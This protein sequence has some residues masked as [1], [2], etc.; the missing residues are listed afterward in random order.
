MNRR[1]FLKTLGA[2]AVALTLSGCSSR[3]TQT[4][5][6]RTKY[7]PRPARNRPN[8]IFIMADDMGYG[9][10][11]VYNTDSKIPTPRMEQLA[12]EGITFTDAHSSAAWC[13]PTRYGLLTGRYHW[14]EQRQEQ[15]G[16][17][18]PPVIKSGRLTI[19][20]LL[21][22]QGY[23][24]A[25]IGKWHLGMEWHM[26]DGSIIPNGRLNQQPSIDFTQPVTEGPLQRGFDYFFGT[27]SCTTDDPPLC[28][29]EN[30]RVIG[31]IPV[32][33]PDH[34]DEG[35]LMYGLPGWKHE[36]ADIEFTKKSVA[37]IET[38]VK[39]KPNAPFFLY[40]ALSVPHVPWLPPDMVK[41]KSK[42]GARGDQ[43]V[44]ADWALGQVL[45][46]LDRLKLTDNTLIIFTSDNGPRKGVNGH[47]SSG[48]WRGYKQDLW[49]GGH[50]EPFIARWPGKLKPGTTSNE[51]LC[52]TDMMATFAA[53]T[54]VSLPDDA[55]EDSFNMLPAILG[56]KAEKPIR[57]AIVH[58]AGA[59]ALAI[60]QGDWKLIFRGERRRRQQKS[61]SG[62]SG[63]L[64]NLKNDPT[65]ED[66][67]WDRY[68]DVV[69]RLTKLLEKYK[70]QGHSRPI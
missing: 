27:S 19:G 47:R 50:R 51:L 49:E 15:L 56:E 5:S 58:R 21:Q 7:P 24:T 38:H 12:S 37:F 20:D 60:R 34:T 25:C 62:A 28:F 64:Y 57:K 67:L 2:S 17:Y 35:R 68:P 23:A 3:I 10:S 30:D 59:V 45:D 54:G 69:E 55:G 18:G 29:I 16:Y 32:K 41:G 14:R 33:V 53:I 11:T 36:D 66:N 43:V 39:E 6:K 1:Q 52:L 31:G 26:K 65:E 9:D 70:E 40:L 48:N 22:R 8:I 61:G 42:A 63:Q 13:I 46:T 44:L 4:Q